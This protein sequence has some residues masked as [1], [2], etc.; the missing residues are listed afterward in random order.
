MTLTALFDLS[1]VGRRDQIA[2]E[3]DR[4]YTFGELDTRVCRMAHLLSARGL[5]TGDRLCIYL[6]NSLEVIELY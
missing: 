5:H 3:W 6:P 1:L 4:E 2:L